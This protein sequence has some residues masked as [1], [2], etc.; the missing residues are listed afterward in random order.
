M[1]LFYFVKLKYLLGMVFHC[2]N[3]SCHKNIWCVVKIKIK[4]LW[5]R[6]SYDVLIWTLAHCLQ[7]Y[8]I[9][10]LEKVK[11]ITWPKVCGHL[12]IAPICE[13][14]LNCVPKVHIV[15]CSVKISHLLELRGPAKNLFQHYKASYIKGWVAKAVVEKLKWHIALTSTKMNTFAINKHW[16][17][18]QS[19]WQTHMG[20]IG[21]LSKY[22]NIVYI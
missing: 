18:A 8:T 19:W 22:G 7:L 10:T 6:F 16:L 21:Q 3:K 13:P 4:N 15:C 20:V 2:W 1:D 17:C 5:T 11:Y 9:Q 12:N 14:L